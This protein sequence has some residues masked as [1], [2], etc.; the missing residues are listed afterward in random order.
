MRKPLGFLLLAAI[1]GQGSRGYAKTWQDH[2]V[3]RQIEN[4][5]ARALDFYQRLDAQDE[6]DRAQEKAASEMSE[7]RLR[8]AEAHKLA[9]EQFV[10]NRKP[11][12][13]TGK[14][15]WE[16]ELKR[17]AQMYEEARERYIE[18]RDEIRRAMANVWRIPDDV[19]FDLDQ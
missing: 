17:R 12:I 9:R 8:R 3:Q 1:L 13:E 6:A 5:R 7:V 19:E 11:K 14:S 15:A 4:L 10:E 18:H 16:L 2:E